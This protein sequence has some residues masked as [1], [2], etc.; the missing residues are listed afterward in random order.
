MVEAES[1]SER[2][3]YDPPSGYPLE[4]ELHGPPPRAIPDALARGP[5][6]RRRKAQ[7]IGVATFGA[8]CLLLEGVPGVDRVAQYVLPL[9][10]LGGIGLGAVVTALGMGA[11]LARR[12][13]PFRYVREGLPLVVRVL[14][15][16]KAPSVIVNGVPSKHAFT[17]RVLFRHPESEE[18]V[19]TDVKSD[20]FS[21]D[22]KDH[23]ECPFRVGDYVTAVYLP[24][25]LAGTLRLYTFLELSA[26]RCLRRDPS[27]APTSPWKAAALVT[28]VVALFAA[29]FGNVYA[30]G[31]FE[32]L[33][34]EYERALLP[35]ILGGVLGGAVLVW[36]YVRH[37]REQTRLAVQAREAARTGRAV[38][39]GTG[40]LGGGAQGW[41]L[42][43]TLAV[44]APLLGAVTVL[45]WSFAANALL[46]AS[47]AR[48]VSATITGKTMTTHVFIFREYQLEYTLAGSSTKQKLLTTPEHLRELTSGRGEALVRSGRFGWPW[49]ETVVPVPIAV[50]S[51]PIAPDEAR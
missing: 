39:T 36:S 5:Y 32:P 35:M 37:R 28:I 43:V 51:P 1:P 48:P 19:L 42:R 3:D 34:F 7:A 20:D 6:A 44:G 50:P 27:A 18:L 16:E 2:I 45:C 12:L 10:Y 13:G 4:P 21:S 29:L 47:P 15:L 41:F 17:A 23:Y 38:E 22:R 8:L 49:V 14:A 11:A 46:D 24:G 26:E 9:G 31:R 25:A 40:F 30:F 33:D